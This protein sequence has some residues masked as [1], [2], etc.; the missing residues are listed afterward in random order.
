MKKILFVHH[1]IG[2]GGAPNSL[3]KLI[4]SLDKN[5]YQSQVLL[6]K[7]SIVSQKLQENNIEYIIAGSLFYK[8]YYQYFTHSELDYIKWFQIFKF[9]KLAILWFLS[10]FYFAKNELKSLDFDLI[11]LNSSVLTDWLAPSKKKGKV[12]IHIRE[13]FRKGNLDFLHLFFR[14]QIDKFSDK[15]IAISNDNKNRINLNEK[16]TVV[17]NYSKIDH[18]K[19]LDKKKYLSKTA[20]YVGGYSKVKGFLNV[21]ESLKHID[22]D[23]RVLFAGYYTINGNLYFRLKLFLKSIFLRKEY[24]LYKYWLE[25]DKAIKI[26]LLDDINDSLD[27][28][29]CLI[30]PFSIPHFSRPIIESFS[31]RKP[32]IATNIPGMSELIINGKNGILVKQN[33]PILL[34]GAINFLC[35]NP[36]KSKEMGNYGY[37]IANKNYSQKNIKLIEDIYSKML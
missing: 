5:N 29:T 17:Y 28:V 24:K 10:R 19:P 13:P 6:I 35:N 9:L 31:R 36:L 12:I 22:D 18:L 4:N 20:L 16:T 27:K 32:A 2:W 8:K 37:L 3:I 1:A 34:A 25:S 23:I 7:D 11:H 26:G 15:I 30:S 33:H 21:V 14:N